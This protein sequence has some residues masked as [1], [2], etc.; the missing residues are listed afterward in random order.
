MLGLGV[1]VPLHEL[2]LRSESEAEVERSMDGAVSMGEGRGLS[3]VEVEHSAAL[4]YDW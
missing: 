2:L 3:E 4:E 1:L